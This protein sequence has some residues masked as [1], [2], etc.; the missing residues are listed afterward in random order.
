M[1][2]RRRYVPHV[3]LLLALFAGCASVTTAPDPSAIRT[4]APTGKLRVGLYPGTPTSIIGEPTSGD[5]KGVGFELGRALAERAGVSFEP[6]VFPRNADVLAAA[7]SGTVDMVFTNATPARMNDMDF[8][9]VVLQIEQGYL[10]PGGSA[11]RARDEIDRTGVRVGVSEGST[12]EATLS[13]ELRNAKVVRTSSLK[14]A[15]DMLSSGRLDAFATNKAT[16]FEISDALPASRVLDGRWGLE[17]FAI[18][19]PEGREAAMPLIRSFV[20]DAKTKDIV[21][22]AVERAGLRGTVLSNRHQRMS[23]PNAR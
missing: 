22:G 8:S 17:S 18:G 3:A 20:G 1:N 6:V 19:I 2:A 10:V 14:T 4:L 15:I 21:T 23:L 13:R 7:K 12:S 5:A 16:L 9:P 11:I